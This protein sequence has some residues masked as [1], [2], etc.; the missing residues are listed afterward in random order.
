MSDDERT[1]WDQR[2][3]TRDAYQKGVRE[4]WDQAIW[5]GIAV[6]VIVYCLVSFFPD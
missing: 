4:G 1:L 6:C 2:K 5:V 3:D